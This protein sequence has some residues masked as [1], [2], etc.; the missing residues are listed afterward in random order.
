MSGTGVASQREARQFL[1]DA[2]DEIRGASPTPQV[3][4]TF[5]GRTSEVERVTSLLAEGCAC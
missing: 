1:V 3:L 5:V 4:A 2:A